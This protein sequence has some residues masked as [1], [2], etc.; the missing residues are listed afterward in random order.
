[1]EIGKEREKEGAKERRKE[2]RKKCRKRWVQGCKGRCKGARV[3]GEWKKKKR[4][5]PRVNREASERNRMLKGRT[6][7]TTPP[8]ETAKIPGERHKNPKIFFLLL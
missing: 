1:M 7:E 5:T 8:L 3:E 4:P 6:L 2:G